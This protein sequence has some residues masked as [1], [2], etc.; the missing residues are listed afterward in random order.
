MKQALCGLFLSL[1]I[2]LFLLP[3]TLSKCGPAPQGITVCLYLKE[4]NK[5]ITLDL[6]EYVMGVVAAEMPA[7]FHPE[8]LKAQAVAA[9]TVTVRRLKRFGGP[10]Y[11]A[12]EGA[13]LSD[14]IND[15]QAW[16]SKQELVGKWGLW[17]YLG[18]WRKI[19]EAVEATGGQILTFQGQPID[20]VYHSTSGPRTESSEAVWGVAL[21]YL[22]SVECLYD[23]HS[24]KY[25][26]EQ[27]F[28]VSEVQAQLQLGKVSPVATGRPFVQILNL[29][30]SGRVNSIRLG[31]K[32]FSGTELRRRLGLN[33]THFQCRLEQDRLIFKTI[34]YGHGVGLCQYG[35][36]GLAKQGRNYRQILAHYYQG[37]QLSK[38]AP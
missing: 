24:P 14:D 35:A 15:S 1:F 25:S 38:L 19:A 10:G 29:T 12:V 30:G 23:Q 9:R 22:R 11:P 8:A 16:L 21:P 5:I 34:G 33:S 6:E 36:D 2:L 37:V 28:T 13:D 18:Y 3:L 17:N 26:Q 27:V 32:V 31:D 7:N 4:A 20:A